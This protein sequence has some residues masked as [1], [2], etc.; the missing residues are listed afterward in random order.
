MEQNTPYTTELATAINNQPTF[1]K[2]YQYN[3]ET[4]PKDTYTYQQILNTL[5]R[6]VAI[7]QG[8]ELLRCY[9]AA[10]AGHHYQKLQ[11]SLSWIF[12]KIANNEKVQIIDYGCGQAL[13]SCV[14]IDYFKDKGKTLDLQKITLIE[15]SLDALNRGLFHLS[16]FTKTSATKINKKLDDLT[17]SD[18]QTDEE[19][20][21]IHLF[22]NILDVDQFNLKV[23]YDKIIQTQKGVNYFVCV[24]PSNPNRKRLTDF[25]DLFSANNRTVY[26]TADG[27]INKEIYGLISKRIQSFEIKMIHQIFGCNL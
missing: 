24:S 18:L 11:I 1:E 21:K 16:Q 26:T 25:C 6:G 5:E 14:L 22:S 12:N 19:L 13:A 15:P 17:I 3:I 9:I 8:D 27:A 2:I 23:L 7:I 20:V 10:Y 4:Y